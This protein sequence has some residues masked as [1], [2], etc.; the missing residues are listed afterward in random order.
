MSEGLKRALRIAVDAFSPTGWYLDTPSHRDRPAHRFPHKRGPQKY[1]RRK[2]IAGG[3]PQGPWGGFL[4]T[5]RRAVWIA[6][7]R[8]NLLLSGG[9]GNL[10]DPRVGNIM[11]L[12]TTISVDSSLRVLEEVLPSPWRASAI[13]TGSQTRS[14]PQVVSL[15]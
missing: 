13:G 6:P 8:K 9:V 14:K 10:R 15:C 5:P 7:L 11:T 3:Y 4:M 12:D 1:P 2:T